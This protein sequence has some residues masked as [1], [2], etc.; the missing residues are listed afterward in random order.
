MAT[1]TTEAPPPA[2]PPPNLS[3]RRPAI[4]DR[5]F[6]YITLACGLLVLL[7][8]ALIA[9][10]TVSKAQPAFSHEGIKFFTTKVWD[11]NNNKFGALAF[12]YGT[13]VTSLIAIVVG[14]PVSIGIALLLTE[15]APRRMR[16]PVVYVID[17]LAAVPSSCS[18]CGGCSSSRSRSTTVTPTSTTG[19]GTSRCST[20]SSAAE[21]TRARRS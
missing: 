5:T 2:S 15:V 21:V 14:V 18:A 16:K 8:L 20:R 17:L 11:P 1:I 3:A 10:A 7:I 12:A 4:A 19:S 6:R 13:M 9:V